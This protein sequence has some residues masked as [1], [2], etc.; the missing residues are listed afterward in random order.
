MAYLHCRSVLVDAF[1]EQKMEFA[2]VRRAD[3]NLVVGCMGHRVRD[4]R[5][6]LNK[7]KRKMFDERLAA[8]VIKSV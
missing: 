6:L 4:R 3:G 7:Y 5:A 2:T 8:I 1:L